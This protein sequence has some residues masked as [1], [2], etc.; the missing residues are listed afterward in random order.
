[1]NHFQSY[2]HSQNEPKQNV[3]RSEA[4]S[5]LILLKVNIIHRFWSLYNEDGAEEVNG[6]GKH[7]SLSYLNDQTIKR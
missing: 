3:F 2:S 7:L 6:R 1:M 4:N 5:I